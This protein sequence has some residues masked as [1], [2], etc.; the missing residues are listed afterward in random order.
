[1]FQNSQEINPKNN[2]KRKGMRLKT[3]FKIY[4]RKNLTRE[5]IYTSIVYQILTAAVILVLI[6][7]AIEG[8][9]ENCFTC[10]LTLILFLMP[11][12]FEKRLDLPLC[13]TLILNL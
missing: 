1:M 11:N 2:R 10:A 9:Y 7:Q 8:R 12:F 6:D 3:R 5:N 4:K 13:G